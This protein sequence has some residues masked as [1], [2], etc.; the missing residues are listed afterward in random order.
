MRSFSYKQ[1]HQLL[2][3]DGLREQLPK[4]GDRLSRCPHFMRTGNENLSKPTP[5]TVIFVNQEHLFFTVEYDGG[6]TEC[7]KLPERSGTW[8]TG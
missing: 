1:A 8:I 5:C 7:F 6:G 4:V 2:T 3:V